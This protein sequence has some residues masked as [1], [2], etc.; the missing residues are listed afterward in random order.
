MISAK[1][2]I[3]NVMIFLNIIIIRVNYN[4]LNDLNAIVKR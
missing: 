1:C 3:A 2:Y 4:N